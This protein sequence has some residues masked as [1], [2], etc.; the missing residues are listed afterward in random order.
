MARIRCPNRQLRRSE[1]G[2]SAVMR[3]DMKTEGNMGLNY[4]CR[5]SGRVCG[6]ISSSASSKTKRGPP[7]FNVECLLRKSAMR[8]VTCCPSTHN[9]QET[10]LMVGVARDG[11]ATTNK[12]H[13]LGP[14]SGGPK[15][16]PQFRIPGGC[17]PKIGVLVLHMSLSVF[18][19]RTHQVV[20]TGTEMV[21][22]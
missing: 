19:S 15:N 18:F 16:L 21:T 17:R 9:A 2:A 10:R 1:A 13:N 20:E 7:S 11:D 22:G 6:R 12:R 3:A 5:N 4:P 8:H 14:A